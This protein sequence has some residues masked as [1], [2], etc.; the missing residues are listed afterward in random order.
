MS[1]LRRKKFKKY[2][3]GAMACAEGYKLKKLWGVI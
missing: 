2:T 1:S 3:V